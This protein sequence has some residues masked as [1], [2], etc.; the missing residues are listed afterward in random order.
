MLIKRNQATLIQVLSMVKD[1]T[2]INTFFL[3][4]RLNRFSIL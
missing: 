4:T 2:F 1:T 3:G